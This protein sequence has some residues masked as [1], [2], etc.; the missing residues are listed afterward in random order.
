VVK[1]VFSTFLLIGLLFPTIIEAEV[2]SEGRK[3]KPRCKGSGGVVVCRMPKP[4]KPKRCVIM[5]CIPSGYYRP[6]PP[7]F[8][9]MR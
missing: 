5:P 4:R 6:N 7:K 1:K 2:S 8:I 9:P 3:R